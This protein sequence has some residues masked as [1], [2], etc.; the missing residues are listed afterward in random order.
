[1]RD[2]IAF[3]VR[4]LALVVAF[5][6]V[7]RAW[8][9]T[10]I[11]DGIEWTYTVVD[12]E[13]SVGS[14]N[15]YG[16]CAV[17]TTTQG[18]IIIP[19]TLGGYTVTS[20]G[21]Y[22]FRGCSGLTSV[23]IGESVTSIGGVAFSNCSGLTSVTIP[24]S[25]TSIGFY[26]FEG[27]SGLTSVTIPDSVTSISSGAFYNC[28]SLTSVTIGDSV[29]SIG[30]RA[31]YDCSGLTSVTIGSGVTSI[32]Y[33]A[34]QGCSGLTSVTIPASVTSIGD[35]AFQNCSGLTS[36]TIPDSV[37]SIGNCAF[38]GCSGLTSV[39]IPDSM[40]S[41]G[42]YAFSGCNGLV[43]V[44]IP[45]SVV[46]IDSNV[47][48][49]CNEML[50]D[51]TTCPGVKLVDGWAVGYTIPYST[52]DLTGVRGIAS[53][54]F[55]GN[56]ALKSV[57]LSDSI[58]SIGPQ[59]FYDCYA[60]TSVIIP[61]SVT[62]IGSWAFHYCT[63]I[64]RG[65]APS[66]DGDIA[67]WGGAA[68]LPNG[69]DTY[70]V[71]NGLW[72]GMTARWYDDVEF[73]VEGGVLTAVEIIVGTDVTIPTSVASISSGAFKN[74]GVMTSVTIPSSVTNIAHSAFASCPNLTHIYFKGD[75]PTVDGEMLEGGF[76]AGYYSSFPISYYYD[77]ISVDYYENKLC[78]VIDRAASGWGEGTTWHGC[79]KVFS[80]ELRSLPTDVIC[81][82][83]V[84]EMECPSY[85]D[86][87]SDLYRVLSY[88]LDSG[89]DAVLHY[90][91]APFNPGYGIDFSI[92]PLWNGA[93]NNGAIRSGKYKLSVVGLGCYT[94]R[95]VQT[96][97]VDKARYSYWG[98]TGRLYLNCEFLWSQWTGD[99]STTI[100]ATYGQP[101]HISFAA[102]LPQEF[103]SYSDDYG[104]YIVR[105]NDQGNIYLDN[106]YD[107]S[108]GTYDLEYGYE[109][110]DTQEGA[111]ILSNLG[112]DYHLWSIDMEKDVG[113]YSIWAHEPSYIYE[114]GYSITECEGHDYLF[115]VEIVPANPLDLKI[116]VETNLVYTE[117][118]YT[119]TP[120]SM[121]IDVPNTYIGMADD[122][123]NS[124]TNV[125]C[126][127]V[128]ISVSG[129]YAGERAVV[130]NVEP[131][132]LVEDCVS[133]T[134]EENPYVYDGYE[135][136]PVVN[137]VSD[138][139]GRR[140]SLGI[141]YDVEYSNNVNPG[142]ATVTVTCKGNYTGTITKTFE[143][144]NADF[145]LVVDGESGGASGESGAI[146]GYEGVYDGEGHGLAVDVSAIGDVGVKYALSEEGP[147]VDSL[148][149]TNVCN[150]TVWVELSAL[151]YNSFTG[152]AQVVIS[153]KSIE[154]CRIEIESP[155]AYD[156]H[157]M[158]TSVSVVDEDL[159]TTLVYGVDY[160][161]EYSE[162]EVVGTA[163]VKVVGLGNYKDEVDRTFEV[164]KGTIRIN[165]ESTWQWIGADGF[166]FD[167]TNKTVAFASDGAV[168]N[169]VVDV[170]ITGVTNA[171]HA[172][173]YTAYANGTMTGFKT[174][175][176]YNYC[177]TTVLDN[178]SCTWQIQPRSCDNCDAS[179][180]P[181]VMFHTGGGLEP[182][183][184]V[185]DGGLGTTLARGVDYELNFRNNVNIGTA[186]VEVEFMGD[187]FGSK[188]LYYHVVDS[189]DSLPPVS[190]ALKSGIYSGAA[191]LV[192]NYDGVAGVD[193]M[194]RYTLDGSE[195]TAQ[196][197]VYTSRVKI[198]I[199]EETWIK[200][201]AFSGDVR[202]S[203]VSV[204]HCF[205]SI[206]SIILGGGSDPVEFGNAESNP[207]EMDDGEMSPAG[208]CTLRSSVGITDGESAFGA[209]V[210]GK[211][212]LAFK[213]Q[214]SCEEDEDYDFCDHA[215]CVVDGNVAA[216]L[217]G[218]SGWV[219]E[220]VEFKEEGEHTIVWKYV[221]DVWGDDSVYP[222][223]NGAWIGD[224]VWTS[225]STISLQFNACGGEVDETERT[226]WLVNPVAA[227]PVPTWA[228][229]DF[230]GWWTAGGVQVEA[231][232][233]L[234]EDTALYAHWTL[235][236]YAVSFDPN[237]GEVEAEDRQIEY[238]AA[239]GELPAPTWEG[240]EFLGW[241][242]LADGGDAVSA[243]TEVLD[244]V[245]LFAHWRKLAFAVS[246]NPN[247]GTASENERTVE[248]GDEIGALPEASWVGREFLGWFVCETDVQATAN[249]VVT[250]D[251]SLEARWRKIKYTVSFD[252]CGGSVDSEDFSI[253][254]E[255]TVGELPVP[256]W[257]GREFLG[258]FTAAEGGEQVDAELQV[259]DAVS[260][261]AHWRKYTFT[262]SFDANGGGIVAE[263]RI[264]EYGD[265]I[266][267]LP[268]PEYEHMEF[269]GWYTPA[270][271]CVAEDTVV[272][273]DM[274]LRAEWRYAFSFDG[275][276]EWNDVGSGVWQSGETPN[277]AT[278][279]VGMEVEGEG[280]I[281]FSWKVSCEDPHIFREVAY[282]LDYLAF[283]IDGDERRYIY[284]TTDWE[285]VS[286]TVVGIGNHVFEWYYVKDS[287]EAAGSDCGWIMDVVWTPRRPVIEGDAE[288]T[289][290]GD[291]E[292]G[293][294]IKPSEG[295]KDVVI[296]IPDGV[297]PEKVTVEVSADVETV[298]ANG[299]TIIVKA[300]GSD[301]T[302]HLSSPAA[303]GDG[304]VDLKAAT[305]KEEVVKET[306]DVEKGAEVDI[307]DPDSPE[308]T[309]SETKPGL[310][311]TL[312]E[313][314]TL[315]AMMS[316]TDGDSK[317]GD[318]EKWT[319]T[320]KVK[321]GP[322]AFYTIE[323]SK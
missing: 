267:E 279:S 117:S 292:S 276:G 76:R 281:T 159:G 297:E 87:A 285:S 169:E 131:R 108:T 202:I 293:Y 315:E 70:V 309:T 150:Q 234:Y 313:G 242:T 296:N 14:G 103:S 186:E 90:S 161:L 78:V 144:V 110:V 149:L 129:N 225:T 203:E 118:G 282:R 273:E 198:N 305:V 200:V 231:G 224:V 151:N 166:A 115:T 28:W 266:G 183:I 133:L 137:V 71:A 265:P 323:V 191:L 4:L 64:F 148:L 232:A 264:V 40:T 192:V 261:F 311:Y 278:N 30:D 182:E 120:D 24:D 204:S 19:T 46:N 212:I 125:G 51:T 245:A 254:Y 174:D 22:A 287:V 257:E 17:P 241:F 154:G 89:D 69:N 168:P 116:N 165:D 5:C 275:D 102:V 49:D 59:A 167:G 249:T 246:F 130:F 47:F 250:A 23:T 44:T 206:A 20:I 119:I 128:N 85:Y 112:Q 114:D 248:F 300:H 126:Y 303:N 268:V 302:E 57:T 283:A 92:I 141:D 42:S 164:V 207:W 140:L 175:D 240:R 230:A 286:F 208:K 27:C 31:F 33:F 122:A 244:A 173:T 214:T 41:I 229:H 181:G 262:V 62:N 39:T 277:S 197:S 43:S 238:G 138:E 227:L 223:R 67:Q 12:G 80:D 32:G 185:V 36:V 21:D 134:V 97:I 178:V 237:G 109:E 316:C 255:D 101:V 209:T 243:E 263:D 247:G 196:S 201:A 199:A 312:L 55:T 195:P 233:R 308:L 190:I 50:F 9:A 295:K 205:P 284:G 251:I 211:G 219:E 88:A 65:D 104:E 260:L 236:R 222:G 3:A 269:L 100:T 271:V 280:T 162:N 289:V 98:Q 221:K 95:F 177:Y 213:W 105:R 96:L 63:L 8:A 54:A 58:T 83:D 157:A 25:I 99:G 253:E 106:G 320:I 2:K 272:T 294:I 153:Q 6:A 79:E 216:Q 127:A 215:V 37:T 56:T 319:P 146:A 158:E 72:H 270:G 86:S 171:V 228:H 93:N 111:C 52:L 15:Y 239:I 160:E 60:L 226:M 142:T 155:V 66:V 180:S 172:G 163:C 188:T 74:C 26:A 1:M 217:C 187:Y 132:Q 259:S 61:A 94:N 290:E 310:T 306:L 252:P 29:T 7:S 53:C 48:N 156:G 18:A 10:E 75:A 184:T 189:F 258:W 321:G 176:F 143:I 107:Y 193:W 68:Y 299:A 210:V 256:T 34:F 139:S 318:G 317:V 11:I 121:Q 194:L 73:T 147:F 274:P 220:T 135:K 314:A 304:I 235:S 38:E 170:E 45:D 81:E 288:A 113:V 291:S 298:K 301:I 16:V 152:F 35:D 84:V 13:A 322:S 307:S 179:L 82:G 145:G 218:E 77:S 124:F 136:L 91:N 123:I